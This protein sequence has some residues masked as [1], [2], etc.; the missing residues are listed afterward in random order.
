M[1]LGRQIKR[2]TQPYGDATHYNYVPYEYVFYHHFVFF[3]VFVF[4]RVAAA[5]WWPAGGQ[6]GRDIKHNYELFRCSVLMEDELHI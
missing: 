1:K 3:F 6:N 2:V 4:G 5:C